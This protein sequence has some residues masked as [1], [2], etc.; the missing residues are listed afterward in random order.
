MRKTWAG[1][2]YKTEVPVTV[3][4]PEVSE[5]DVVEVLDA[6]SRVAVVL[7]TSSVV[8]GVTSRTA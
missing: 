6:D 4:R 2:T 8:K 7:N 1:S 3:G 5:Q